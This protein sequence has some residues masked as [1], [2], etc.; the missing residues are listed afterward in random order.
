MHQSARQLN[1]KFPISNTNVTDTRM[2]HEHNKIKDIN[3]VGLNILNES[4][5]FINTQSV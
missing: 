3:T 2:H 4:I 5:L 1:V